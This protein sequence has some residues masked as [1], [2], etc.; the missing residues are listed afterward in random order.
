MLG[1]THKVL[2]SKLFYQVTEY[3]LYTNVQIHIFEVRI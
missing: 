2:K 3:C 1:Y